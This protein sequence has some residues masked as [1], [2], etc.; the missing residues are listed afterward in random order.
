[1]GT[2]SNGKTWGHNT[3]RVASGFFYGWAIKRGIQSAQRL[4]KQRL[5]RQ[6]PKPENESYM[7]VDVVRVGVLWTMYAGMFL[8]HAWIIINALVMVLT[9]GVDPMRDTDAHTHGAK[10]ALMSAL[11]AA[12]AIIFTC[13]TI[14]AARALI[15][16]AEHLPPRKGDRYLNW[17]IFPHRC[18]WLAMFFIPQFAYCPLYF[19]SK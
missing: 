10:Y 3:G 8:I 12:P 7:A 18:T 17:R 2:T 14:S 15:A 11:Y 6:Q 16:R 4:E 9:A 13:M 5:E 19:Y 1:M